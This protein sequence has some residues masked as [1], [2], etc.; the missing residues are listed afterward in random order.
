[1]TTNEQAPFDPVYDEDNPYITEVPERFV[2]DEP[3]DEWGLAEMAGPQR[4]VYIDVL[5]SEIESFYEDVFIAQ[6]DD[7]PNP[8]HGDYSEM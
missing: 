8:Y 1:M 7:D 3:M 5:R 4:D 6:W 2:Y